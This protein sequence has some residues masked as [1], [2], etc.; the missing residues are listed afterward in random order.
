MP[1]LSDTFLCDQR[2]QCRVVPVALPPPPIFETDNEGLE[3]ILTFIHIVMIT[4][5]VEGIYDNPVTWKS[6]LT[7]TQ[8]HWKRKH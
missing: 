7:V 1:N 4:R 6:R 3:W 8:G 5:N 2:Q